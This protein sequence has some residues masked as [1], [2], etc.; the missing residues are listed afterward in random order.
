MSATAIIITVADFT[1]YKPIN[2]NQNQVAVLNRLIREAQTFDLK[3]LMGPAF[4]NE[5][6]KGISASPILS[7]WAD[8]LVGKEY[9]NDSAD[10]IEFQGIKPC[11][12]YFAH[13]RYVCE[14]NITDTP[15]GLVNKKTNFSE[16]IDGKAI[17]ILSNKSKHGATAYWHDIEAFLNI[18]ANVAVY[19][20]WNKAK[21]ESTRTK[22]GFVMT[23]VS[24]NRHTHTQHDH[25]CNCREC[26]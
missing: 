20:K 14:K 9:T 11:L 8:L 7:K 2:P 10:V 12:V 6:V 21:G 19:P 24:N 3:P 18:K 13:A 4:Y 26:C 25:N 16:G 17:A 22:R 1:E 15:H 23:N 5:F